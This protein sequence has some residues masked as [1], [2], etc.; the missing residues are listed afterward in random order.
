MD[1]SPIDLKN[2]GC[3]RTVLL[4]PHINYYS[5]WFK[6]DSLNNIVDF[7]TNVC[8]E[9]LYFFYMEEVASGE[10]YEGRKD[11]GNTVKGYGVKYKGRGLGQTTGYR[12]YLALTTY[13]QTFLK[14]DVNF[15]KN[16]ELLLQPKWA[17]LSA[18]YFW[19]SNRLHVWSD[20]GEFDKVCNVWNTGKPDRPANHLKERKEIRIK[21]LAW[22]TKILEE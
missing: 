3:Q 14:E 8:H 21:V 22:A 9:T 11:L 15:V 6:M 20:K 7:L 2:L 19:D 18:F 1:L 4:T 13:A 17:V 5:K 12:N 16:P 10:A